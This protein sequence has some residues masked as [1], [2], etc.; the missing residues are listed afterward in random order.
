MGDGT[1]GWKREFKGGHLGFT[2][3]RDLLRKLKLLFMPSLETR[4][5]QPGQEED[6]PVP[7]LTLAV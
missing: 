4:Q 5:N 2:S 1:Y 7:N 6:K 3:S